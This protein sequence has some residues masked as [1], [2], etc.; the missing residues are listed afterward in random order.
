[1]IN[2]DYG[3]IIVHRIEQIDIVNNNRK[4]ND[5]KNKQKQSQD[6][7]KKENNFGEIFKQEMDKII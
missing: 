4:E 1:M 7:K 6:K 5:L 3:K 2:S